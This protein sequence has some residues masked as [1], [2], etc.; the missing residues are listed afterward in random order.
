MFP[1]CEALPTCVSPSLRHRLCI[2]L[3]SQAA[4]S[5]PFFSIPSHCPTLSDCTDLNRDRTP[6]SR[7]VVW[8]MQQAGDGET[9]A[10]NKL[11]AILDQYKSFIQIDGDIASIFD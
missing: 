8:V 7:D 3:R 2:V 5:L 4:Q 1:T 11:K 9:L 10:G 6:I